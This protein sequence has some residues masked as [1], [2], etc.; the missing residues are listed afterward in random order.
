M[1]AVTLTLTLTRTEGPPVPPEEIAEALASYVR[2]IDVWVYD[3]RYA[4]EG[5]ALEE[6]TAEAMRDGRAPADH[7]MWPIFM[8]NVVELA[9][10]KR[11]PGGYRVKG[12]L[13][14]EAIHLGRDRIP[15][16]PK[17]LDSVAPDH[18]PRE[19][20]LRVPLLVP[21]GLALLVLWWR[22]SRRVA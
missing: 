21:G 7:P 11:T 6:A 19:R 18:P 15:F 2:Q 13:P 4:V 1:P 5:A 20:P 12:L 8:S 9:G 17:V 10:G 16:D 3:T 14:P 22:G